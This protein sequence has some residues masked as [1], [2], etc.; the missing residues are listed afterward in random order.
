MS[1]MNF[2]LFCFVR[3]EER[4]RESCLQN[5]T[6]QKFFCAVSQSVRRNVVNVLSKSMCFIQDVR[7]LVAATIFSFVRS[8][9]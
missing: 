3:E 6:Y 5:A 4:A 2:M 1:R 8:F 7:S 9:F